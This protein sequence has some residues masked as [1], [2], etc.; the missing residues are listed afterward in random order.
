MKNPFV[1]GLVMLCIGIGIGWVAKPVPDAGKSGVVANSSGKSAPPP[2]QPGPPPAADGGNPGKRAIR[3]PE[4]PKPAPG[5]PTEEQMDQAKKMQSEMAKKMVENQRTKFQSQ[6]DRL[7]EN[8]A[9]TDAQK[10]KLSAWL[11]ERFQ[12][13]E[14]L[15][16][17]DPVKMEEFT[18]QAGQLNDAALE[19]QLDGT[20][21]PEQETALTD[22]KTRERASK[23]D[24]LA[25]KSLSNLQGLIQF[26]AGQRDKVYEILSESAG[27][28]LDAQ[29]K[30]PDVSSMFTEGMGIEMDPYGL[31][32]QEAFTESMGG[33]VKFQNDPE[34]QQGLA[35]TLR[36]VINGRID[37]KV[38][39]LRPVLND[40]Q[41]ENY[42]T[43]LQTK[44]LGVY[45]TVL[46]TMEKS[47]GGQPGE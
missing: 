31:G 28:T 39:K 29:S 10:S 32:I 11:D 16:F 3:P 42:R 23:V 1:V 37:A 18:K 43:G 8:V 14:N 6:I 24:A 20:L 44:G 45:G 25:L 13:F 12:G 9:L 47:G 33:S 35:K 4:P 2:P 46:E 41:L 19:A 15:D 7:S 30:T 21:S 17:T 40:K 27:E 5:M 38:E 34:K 26:E 22:F 36:E